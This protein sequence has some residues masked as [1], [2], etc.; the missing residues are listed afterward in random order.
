MKVGIVWA[1][2]GQ[3]ALTEDNNMYADVG[4]GTI[5]SVKVWMFM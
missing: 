2:G 5:R 3:E 4:Y 1:S